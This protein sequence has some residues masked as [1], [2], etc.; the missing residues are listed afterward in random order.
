MQRILK[1]LMILSQV[2][3][4]ESEII[5]LRAKFNDA[6]ERRQ[7]SDMQLAKRSAELTTQKEDHAK[8]VRQGQF[9]SK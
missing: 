4:Y 1:I 5:D 3:E 8:I 6:E 9:P 2:E 7:N